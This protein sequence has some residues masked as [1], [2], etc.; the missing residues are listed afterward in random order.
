MQQN[1]IEN[2]EQRSEH[3]KKKSIYKAGPG[4]EP[5]FGKASRV[6]SVVVWWQVYEHS[7]QWDE[8]QCSTAGNWVLW[9]IRFL[10]LI[11][12]WKYFYLPVLKTTIACVRPLLPTLSPLSSLCVCICKKA[13][14]KSGT[15]YV[16]QSGATPNGDSW[17]C[18][19]CVFLNK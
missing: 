15:V 17:S 4:G 7:W 3:E 19:D 18:S 5:L 8:Q 12:P 10:F 9:G 14:E 2:R 13:S 1:K 11:W 6:L 16:F